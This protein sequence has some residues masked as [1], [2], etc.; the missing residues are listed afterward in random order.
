MQKETSASSS[1]LGQLW[2]AETKIFPN[3][4]LIKAHMHQSW[5]CLVFSSLYKVSTGKCEGESF[6]VLQTL[7]IIKR[8]HFQFLTRKSRANAKW[9]P[10]SCNSL[11]VM[12]R[13][14][15]FKFSLLFTLLQLLIV[16]RPKKTSCIVIWS[17][18]IEWILKRLIFF[19]KCNV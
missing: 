15:N 13:F 6:Y 11:F 1:V 8:L 17:I 16:K 7:R 12:T 3:N 2:W 5:K 9:K 4:Q 14:F 18:F 19:M 10:E